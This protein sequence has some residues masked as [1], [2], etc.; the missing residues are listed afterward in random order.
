MNNA[1]SSSS[2]AAGRG[3]TLPLN[4]AGALPAALPPAGLGG[5]GGGGGGTGGTPAAAALKGPASLKA[6]LPGARASAAAVGVSASVAS[7]RARTREPTANQ[8]ERQRTCIGTAGTDTKHVASVIGA[9]YVTVRHPKG[10][11]PQT[12]R[13]GSAPALEQQNRHKACGEVYWRRV[14]DRKAPERGPTA[15]LG[16]GS[17]PALEQKSR[18]KA[19]GDVNRS[20][21]CDRTAP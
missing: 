18:H 14:C 17:A 6:L 20:G 13:S 4:P 21:E 5:G 15:D 19:C 16:S 2:Y 7:S 11:L 9:E 3:A 1:F 10:S 8:G 12:R